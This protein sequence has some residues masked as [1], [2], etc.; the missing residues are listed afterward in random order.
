MEEERDIENIIETY[1]VVVC[2]VAGY[3][4]DTCILVPISNLLPD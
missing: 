4:Q 1:T 3:S 2:V